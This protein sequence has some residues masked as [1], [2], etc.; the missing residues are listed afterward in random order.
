MGE[1]FYSFTFNPVSLSLTLN[2]V[3]DFAAGRFVKQ[4]RYV[5]ATRTAYVLYNE[6]STGS[7]VGILPLNENG[8]PPLSATQAFMLDEGTFASDFAVSPDGKTIYLP[9][10]A[11]ARLYVF[12]YDGLSITRDN[13]LTVY[14]PTAPTRFAIVPLF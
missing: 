11:L 4:I 6:T 12:R 9:L 14:L 10:A 2:G 5:E 8:V 1:K 13:D 3:T 7:G